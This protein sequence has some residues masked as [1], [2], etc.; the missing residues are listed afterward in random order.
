M[1]RKNWPTQSKGIFYP[2]YGAAKNPG[3]SAGERSNQIT[4]LPQGQ[5]RDTAESRMRYA[6][7]Q[8]HTA[9]SMRKPHR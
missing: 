8:K 4:S 2:G 6:A 9:E 5:R 1:A 7:K 3:P